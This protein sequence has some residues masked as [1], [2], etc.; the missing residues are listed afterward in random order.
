M[1]RH[2]TCCVVCGYPFSW[3][4]DGTSWQDAVVVSLSPPP[5]PTLSLSLSLPCLSLCRS[6]SVSLTK[7]HIHA[8]T[9]TRTRAH[10]HVHTRTHAHAH[11]HTRTRTRTHAHALTHGRFRWGLHFRTRS[12]EDAY[13]AYV[14]S[15]DVR[16]PFLTLATFYM[17]QVVMVALVLELPPVHLHAS[18]DPS[19]SSLITTRSSNHS[20]TDIRN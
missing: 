2:A 9:H 16:A 10:A 15:D 1:L 14:H 11:T 13:S 3:C 17:L 4:D 20:L 7:R 8:L 19:T 18:L 12:A 6:P 5:P